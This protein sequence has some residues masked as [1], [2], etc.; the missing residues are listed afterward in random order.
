MTLFD[1][2]LFWLP[3]SAVVFWIAYEIGRRHGER[4][5]EDRLRDVRLVMIA[6]FRRELR[7]AMDAEGGQK[8]S[9]ALRVYGALMR[10]LEAR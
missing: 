5:A 3:A 2:L 8:S 6:V 1:V 7:E 9:A 4:I 10:R